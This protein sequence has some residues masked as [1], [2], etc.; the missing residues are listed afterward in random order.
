LAEQVD[1][2][3][4]G[5]AVQKVETLLETRIDVGIDL[6]GEIDVLGAAV[7]QNSPDIKQNSADIRTLLA[8]VRG[9]TVKV[10]T[11]GRLEER[12]SVLE[13]KGI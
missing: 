11:P 6:S 7:R 13:R 1:S 4:K 9:L 3:A 8:D 12:V 10:A 5:E 2:R